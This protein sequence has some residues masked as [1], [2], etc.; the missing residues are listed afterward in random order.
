MYTT[1]YIKPVH[2]L[3]VRR[4]RSN[5]PARGGITPEVRAKKAQ[6]NVHNPVHNLLE[7]WVNLHNM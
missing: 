2:P 7:N 4:K 3:S 5:R 6:K 1:P